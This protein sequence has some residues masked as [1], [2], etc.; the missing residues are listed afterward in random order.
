MN[1][2]AKSHLAKPPEKCLQEAERSKKQMYLE[3]CL[4][5]RRHFSPYFASGNGLLVVEAMDTLKRITVCMATKWWKPYSR[6]KVTSRVGLPSLWCGPH[7]DASRVPEFR[8][9]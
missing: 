4:Q 6:T 9:I 5:Q 8:I 1:T 7:I 3:A 2:D